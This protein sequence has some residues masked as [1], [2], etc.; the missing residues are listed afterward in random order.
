MSTETGL[1]AELSFSSFFEVI[2]TNDIQQAIK[3][4]EN[5]HELKYMRKYDA[6]NAKKYE[7]MILED[8]IYIKKLGAG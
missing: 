5:N 3:K 4:N 8:M 7:M 6:S 2:G 1:L